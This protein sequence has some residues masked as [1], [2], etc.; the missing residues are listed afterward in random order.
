VKLYHWTAEK[1]LVGIA[2]S[3]LQPFAYDDAAG[4]VSAGRKV[5]WLTASETRT[6]DLEYM[7]S[8][9]DL[10][11]ATYIEKFSTLQF[12][13]PD[14]V[15]LT[16]KFNSSNNQR[17]KKFWPWYQQFVM[18]NPVTGEELPTHQIFGPGARA[19]YFVHLGVIPARQIEFP[20]ITARIALLGLTD[21][22]PQRALLESVPPDTVVELIAAA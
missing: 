19:N 22:A 11:S 1:N 14:D 4:L 6:P 18:A 3:G 21:D 12:G 17:L 2:A 15:R 7:K 10:F 16:V 8:R 13:K 20:P 5:V 9:P